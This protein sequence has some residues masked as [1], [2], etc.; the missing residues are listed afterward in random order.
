MP[1]TTVTV[2]LEDALLARAR[3]E[4]TELSA[5]VAAALR[6]YLDRDL[7]RSAADRR[8]AEDNALAIEALAAGA[9]ETR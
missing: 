4:P 5:T 9:E 1:E 8:W 6:Q 2:S 7:G 3:A